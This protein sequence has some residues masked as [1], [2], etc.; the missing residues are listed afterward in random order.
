M[1]RLKVSPTR[2]NLLMVRQR[3]SLAREGFR[4]LDRKRDVLIMEIMQV[5]SSAE[6]IQ[7]QVEGQFERAYA[8][9]QQARAAMGT[10]RV[11]RIALS[12]RDQ[13][14]VQIT[15]RSIMGVVVPHVRYSAPEERLLYGL[16]DT[17]VTL[18]QVQQ[19]WTSVVGMMGDLAQTVTTVWR[20]AVELKRTQRRVNALENVHIPAYEETVAYIEGMLE[21][22]EREELF[23]MKRAKAGRETPGT[24]E[25]LD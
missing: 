5:I 7:T 9:V 21:E 20:L 16:G 11:R 23:R 17:N 24:G 25:S 18:D 3:L 19:E 10:E 1:A 15:P 2:S 12:R 4:L 13:V 6:G 22:K 8:S 14:D